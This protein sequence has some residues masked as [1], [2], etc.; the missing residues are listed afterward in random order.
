[1]NPKYWQTLELPK[2]LS[3]LAEHTSFSAGRE[4]AL[5]LEPATTLEE[6]RCRQEET[7]QARRLLEVKPDL[8]L[9]GAHDVRPLVGHAE[10]G[11]IL[12]PQDLLDIRDTLGCGRRLRR[13]ITR[14]GEQFPRLAAIAAHIEECPELVQEIDRC[15][16]DQGEVLDRASPALGRIRR[17]LRIAHNRLMERLQRIITSPDYAPFLQESLITQREGRYVVPLRAECKGRIPGLV[18]DRSASGATLFIEPLSVVDLNNRWRELQLEEQQEVERILRTLSGLVAEESDAIARTVEALA[19]LDLAFAKAQYAEATHSVE[20]ILVPFANGE[21][22]ITNGESHPTHH[23]IRNTHHIAADSQSVTPA[24]LYHPGSTINLKRARH[25]LLPPDQVVPIDVYIT[26]RFFILVITGPNTGGKTVTL[27]TVG[28]L[29]LMAQCGLHI[30]AA[31]GSALSVFSGV[32][33]DIGDE[34]SIEQSLSTFSSHMGNIIDILQEADEHSLVLLDEIGAGTDPVEGSALARAILSHLRERRITTLATTHY[35]E[36]KL[37][38]HATPG[39]ENACVEFDL[40]TLSP[41]YELTIGLPGRSNAFAIAT[42]LGLPQAIVNQARRL[43]SAEDLEAD[44]LLAEIKRAHQEALEARQAAEAARAEAE[45][46]R[47]ELQEKLY[48]LEAT[49][50]RILQQAREEARQ[51]LEAVREELRQVRR[52]LAR[53]ARHRKVSLPYIPPIEG[54]RGEEPGEAEPLEELDRLGE[55]VARLE[56]RLTPLPSPQPPPSPGGPLQVGDTVWVKGL[57][58]SGEII[59]LDDS[60]AEVQVGS[61]RVRASLTDLERLTNHESRTTEHTPHITHHELPSPPSPGL[62]LD[63]RGERVEDMLPRLE[64]YID[65]AYLAGMPFVRIIHGKG[66]GALRRAVR[67]FLQ[68]H[69]LVESFRPGE[70]GEGGDGVTVVRLAETRSQ[71]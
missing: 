8:H 19:E 47:Q 55:Q 10:R 53:L 36:L 42:R 52:R 64:K 68:G 16:N 61:F 40:E 13:A 28:L 5:A 33:A 49:R 45:Q 46:L 32:Y 25:P 56:Q 23:A 18:H 67:Q 71:P 4:L 34:Q 1:V 44:S 6:V 41:T 59:A 35:S 11:G 31:D 51:E 60:Q 70:E 38:A 43:V 65:D 27:K 3:R 12:Q 69:P 66:T 50:H 2:I 22:Q 57:Q 58:A 14:L 17:E 29:S 20:P 26:D 9:G 39:V 24:S 37:Y 15:L 54:E 63:L 62:E 21:W 7:T 30:P 48:E